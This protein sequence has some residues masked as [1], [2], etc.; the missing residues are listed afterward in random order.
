MFI[1]FLPDNY[2]A[3]FDFLCRTILRNYGHFLT[4][5]CLIFLIHQKIS[6][7]GLTSHSRVMEIIHLMK[8]VL[9]VFQ[10]KFLVYGSYLPLMKS[11]CPLTCSVIQALLTEEEN[12]LIINRL[13]Q[14]LRPFVLRRLKHK[15]RIFHYLYVKGSRFES[16]TPIVLCI[17]TLYCCIRVIVN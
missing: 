7:N 6:R 9:L 4:S 8:W 3:Y 15:V 1:L 10:W 2:F 17:S 13:H 11:H 14:V 16:M 5:Y 12:L